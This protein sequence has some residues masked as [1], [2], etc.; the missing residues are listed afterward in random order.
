MCC[1]CRSLCV[2]LNLYHLTDVMACAEWVKA[3]QREGV[4]WL[5]VSGCDDEFV[6][7]T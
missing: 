6:P 5:F 3:R 4:L 2:I 1:I 7:L